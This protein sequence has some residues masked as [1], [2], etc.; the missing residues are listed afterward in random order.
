MLR[1]LAALLLVPAVAIAQAPN[2]EPV[3]T[4]A[5]FA[6]YSDFATNLNDALTATG[7]ARRA[8]QPEL[9]RAAP[10]QI[11]FDQLPAS[12]R[13]AWNR[14]VDYYAE[15]VAVVRYT[16]RERLLLRLALAGIA[17]DEDW[18]SDDDRRHVTIGRGFLNAAAPAYG[19]CRWTEQDARNREWIAAA[20]SL[21]AQHEQ[22]LGDR[23]VELYEKPWAGLPFR[24]DIVETVGSDGASAVNLVPPG[25]H[26]LVSSG[27]RANRNHAAVEV[28]FHEAA[29]FL[30]NRDSP[31]QRALDDAT[32][33]HGTNYRGDLTHAA[34]FYITG[35]AVRRS[36]AAAGVRDYTPYIYAQNLYTAEFRDR[37]ERAWQSYVGGRGTLASATDSFVRSLR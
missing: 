29:H 23:L 17:S 20:E 6:F 1:S 2:G 33:E 30:A 7:A 11:C 31:L 32:L 8:K 18:S 24:V 4:T 3:T 12:E 10:E 16:E 28:L 37:L 26:I 34:I 15:I 27:A 9:F 22:A 36:F 25:L 5:H 14:A 35:E 21:L 13:A 19:R